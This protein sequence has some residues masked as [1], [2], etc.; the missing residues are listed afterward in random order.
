MDAT[1]TEENKQE[2]D[3]LPNASR[4][5][6]LSLFEIA[7][8]KQ[9]RYLA[10]GSKLSSFVSNQEI[11]ENDQHATNRT[12]S[13]HLKPRQ[14]LNASLESGCWLYKLQQASVSKNKVIKC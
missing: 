2:S 4:F 14:K 3:V 10:D 9:I 6:D 5:L 11:F 12:K 13:K 1:G 8:G 7:Y